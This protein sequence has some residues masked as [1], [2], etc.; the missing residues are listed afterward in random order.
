VLKTFELANVISCVILPRDK[1]AVLGSKT[2]MLY[3]L[4]LLTGEVIHEL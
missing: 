4:D 2:G 1:F 3:L